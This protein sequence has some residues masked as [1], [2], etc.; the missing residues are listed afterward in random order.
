VEARIRVRV[1]LVSG[2]RVV[3]DEELARLLVLVD[4]LGSLLAASKALHIPYSR[5]WEKIASA[6]KAAGGKLIEARRG[7]PKGGGARLTG[8][9]RRLLARYLAE[10]RRIVGAPLIVGEAAEPPEVGV[11]AGSSDYAVARLVGLLRERGVAA[12]A[13]WLGSARGVAALVLGEA[14]IAGLH[15]HVPGGNAGYLR[16]LGLGGEVALVRG[17]ERLQGFLSRSPMTLEDIMRGLLE[18]RLRL[19]N[20]NRG[21]GTRMLLDA[22]L[23]EWASRLGVAGGPRRV[24]GYGFEASTHSEVAEAVAKG[25]ADVGLAVKA[26]AALHG[27][28]FTSVAWERFDFAVRAGSLGEGFV[29][30]FLEALGSREFRRILDSLEGYRAPGDMGRVEPLSDIR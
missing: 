2:G 4:R 17:Y 21:S 18:G 9:A 11:Y 23:G 14:D 10:Y 6:E 7:G 3:L 15:V 20:R 1:E 26:A 16:S 27:L 13:Y 22:L 25:D 8:L 28:S 29:G 19:V 24:R 5:A 30:D 12:E